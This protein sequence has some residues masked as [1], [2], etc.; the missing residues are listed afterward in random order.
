MF[1]QF[2]E[3]KHMLSSTFKCDQIHQCQ[4]HEFGHT[5][6]LLKTGS[7]MN[8]S[9]CLAPALSVTKFTNVRDMNLVTLC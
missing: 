7:N 4:R 9:S 5:L 6:F 1:S 2:V 3:K 8:K